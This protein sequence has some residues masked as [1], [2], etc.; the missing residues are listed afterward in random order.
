MKSNFDIVFTEDPHGYVV[1]GHSAVSVTQVLDDS[2]LIDF[3]GI[4]DHTL[5]F[6]ASRGQAVHS[7]T[8]YIDD[9]TIDWSTLDPRIEGYLRAYDKFKAESGFIPELIEVP[10][11]NPYGNYAGMVDRIGFMNDYITEIDFK[12]GSAPF[13]V[14]LQTAAYAAACGHTYGVHI[15]KRFALELKDSGK[16]SLVAC[17]NPADY[18][19]FETLAAA[20]HIKKLGKGRK[21]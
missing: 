4:P 17:T 19:D 12:T 6:A 8:H 21:R 20:Y 9:E 2:G 18:Q 14:G 16:Y 5:E 15:E 7:A 1:D 10:V 13:W 11:Y 3:E